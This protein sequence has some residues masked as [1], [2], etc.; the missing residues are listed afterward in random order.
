MSA[1]PLVLAHRPP[2]AC[3]ETGVLPDALCGGGQGWGVA[4]ANE[5]IASAADPLSPRVRT[6]C[7]EPEGDGCGDADCREV[8]MGAAVISGVDS[9]P[10]FEAPNM[11]SILWRCL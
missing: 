11:F 2:I 9:P 8:G 1:E 6:H 5:A 3:R 4:R 7:S 10:I